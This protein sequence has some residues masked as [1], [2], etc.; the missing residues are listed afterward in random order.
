MTPLT[1][2]FP[3]IA[4]GHWVTQPGKEADLR[5]VGLPLPKQVSLHFPSL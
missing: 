5:S 2:A 3:V 1:A 4:L